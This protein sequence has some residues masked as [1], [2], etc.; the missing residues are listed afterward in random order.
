MD[1]H[2]QMESSGFDRFCYHWFY[3][4]SDRQVN[5]SI[6]LR[7]EDIDVIMREMTEFNGFAWRV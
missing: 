1:V 7:L 4:S 6:V 2:P 3:E 5:L